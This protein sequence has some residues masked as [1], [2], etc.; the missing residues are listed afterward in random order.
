MKALETKRL[1]LRGWQ[2]NDLHDFFEYA[3]N[4]NVGPPAGWEPHKNKAMSLDVLE[5]FIE[6]DDIWAIVCKE[7]QKT[8]G[9]IGLH[10]DQKREGV[11]G[12]MLGYA[13][14]EAYWGKGLMTE[15]AQCVLWHAFTEMGLELVSVFH[16]PFNGRSK[17]VI[18]KCGFQYEGTLR[19]GSKLY[20]GTIY[21]N[22]CYSLLRDEFFRMTIEDAVS[23]AD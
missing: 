18:E 12:K 8:I 19:M 11:N 2:L 20:D 17:R 3:K 22:V 14:S 21:D 7:T 6:Q 10:K 5:S 13:M 15:A 16:Y 1:I 4:P 9:S 23:R